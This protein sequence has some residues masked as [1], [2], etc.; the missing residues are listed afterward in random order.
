MKKEHLLSGRKRQKLTTRRKI[1]QAANELLKSK[2]TLS[3]EA[4]ASKAG[5]S[6]ATVYRYYS[7]TD[8]I[9]TELIL[10]LNVPS[11]DSLKVKFNNQPLMDALLGI[12]ETYLDFIF[13][14]EIPS[15]KFLGAMLSSSDPKLERG[16]NRITAIRNFFDDNETGLSEGA[17]KNLTHVAVLL[18]GIEAIMVT[19]DVCKLTNVQSRETLRWGLEMLVKGCLAEDK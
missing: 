11:G 1:L 2:R 15:K 12:Q 5:I 10:Q 13:G 7:S 6:R 16:Q 19:K 18:M 4:I 9:A 17:K 8:S 14:N 3:M